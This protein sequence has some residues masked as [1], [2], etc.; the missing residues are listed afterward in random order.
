[1]LPSRPVLYDIISKAIS[2]FCLS[3]TRHRLFVGRLAAAVDP[4]WT[5]SHF[6]FLSNSRGNKPS[7]RFCRF[8]GPGSHR[9][10]VNFLMIR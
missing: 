6:H 4:S 9:Y 10:S 3:R 1:M 5:I 7:L 8:A 2:I